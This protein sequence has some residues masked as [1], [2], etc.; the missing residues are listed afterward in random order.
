MNKYWILALIFSWIACLATAWEARSWYDSSGLASA[1][2]HKAKSL[3]NGE[4]DIIT[5]DQ[6]LNKEL[7]NDK[8]PCLLDKL[9]PSFD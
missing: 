3:G 6:K 4:A 8:D 1:Q 9:P 5:E 7:Q 2:A